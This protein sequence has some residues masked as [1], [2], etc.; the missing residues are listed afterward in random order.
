MAPPLAGVRV[1]DLTR[2]L[3][4][5]VCTLH[6]ADLGADVVK[7]EDLGAGDYAR[8]LGI[9][10]SAKSGSVS[11]FYAIVN[12]NKRSLA[13]DLKRDAGRAAFLRLVKQADVIVES[14]R[15]GVVARLGVGYAD[16]VAV[17]AR[18]VYCSISG[19]GQDGPYR[20][21]AGH[22]IN[23]LGYAGVLEQTG[24]AGGA[25]ALSNLQIADLLGG[26]VDAAMTILAALFDAQR[27]GRGRYIDV[28][29]AEAALA[30]NIFPLHMLEMRGS[31]APR[32]GDLLTG[33]AP[34]YGVYATRDGRHMAV[35]ALEGKFWR[36]VCTV[37]GRPD[38]ESKQFATGVEGQAARRAVE[39]IFATRTRDEW[40]ERFAGTDCCV[41]PVLT[42]EEALTDEQFVARDM[43][44]EG[45]SGLRQYASPFKLSDHH[46][47]IRREAP[48][49]GE[50]SEE[51]LRE[52]GFDTGEIAALSAAGVIRGPA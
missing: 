37:L 13:I 45:A 28:A 20:D 32:G 11:A 39:A 50:H 16:A 1:L 26:S 9:P 38:L 47:E 12:R 31:V 15:P 22:D 7:I 3:P 41:T 33:G 23:Y 51:V 17:N 21:R 19:Y 42:L 14:F 35:G 40:V 36:G 29:M 18:I 34:C 25:P 43:V 27:R 10:P 4:G 52:N 6:L 44:A 48:A 46:F 2:L 8:A 24:T 49:Q 5:S 30:H